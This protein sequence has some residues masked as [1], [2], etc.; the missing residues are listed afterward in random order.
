M[1]PPVGTTFDC[2]RWIEN[3]RPDPNYL[4]RLARREIFN[5]G[6]LGMIDPHALHHGPT[7]RIRIDG[8]P[9]R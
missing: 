6:H 5:L 8:P 3:A 2:A 1:S 4:L 7:G 9:T